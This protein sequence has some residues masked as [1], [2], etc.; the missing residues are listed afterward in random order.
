MA[1]V[2]NE[3]TGWY[4][5]AEGSSMKELN[6]L[7]AQ[8]QQWYTTSVG[9]NNYCQG[10][11]N[12]KCKK[13]TGRSKD[14][15]YNNMLQLKKDIENLVS[16]RDELVGQASTKTR[17]KTETSAAQ[18]V[19]HQQEILE[20]KEWSERGKKWGIYAGIGAIILIPLILIIRRK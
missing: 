4:N 17:Q 5:A 11:S 2:L 20:Q 1:I 13:R 12:R 9:D 10:V 19:E 6:E 15:V 7:I 3:L 18:I 16:Q 8:K 14:S